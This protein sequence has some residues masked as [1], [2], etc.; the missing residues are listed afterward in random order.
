MAKLIET[1]LEGELVFEEKFLDDE[2][3]R[4]VAE[5]E[6]SC[7]RAIAEFKLHEALAKIWELFT[8]ANVYVDENKPWA[9]VGDHL[10]PIK[11]SNAGAAERQF[12]GAGHFLKTITSLLYLIINAAKMVEP[13]L[14][15]TA[16]KIFKTFGYDRNKKDLNG[17][18]FEVAQIEA[19]FPRI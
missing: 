14:P 13:F 4:K 9:D 17:L 15:E 16:E 8:Y 2:I 11:S 7:E 6:E 12:D 5:A 1:K 3:K 19:L 10:Y 18:K